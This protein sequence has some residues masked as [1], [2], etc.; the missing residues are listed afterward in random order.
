MFGF[1]RRQHGFITALLGCW[2]S[3]C[4]IS[5]PDPVVT[6]V[7]PDQ[8]WR[9]ES[10]LVQILG[11]NFMPGFSVEAGSDNADLDRDFSAWLTE[12]SG[13]FEDIPLSGVSLESYTRLQGIVPPGL[14]TGLYDLRVVGPT[15][16]AGSLAGA[17]TVSDSQADRL[18]L[19]PDTPSTTVNEPIVVETYL[20]DPNGDR[21]TQADVEVVLFLEDETGAIVTDA[22]FDLG[23]LQQPVVD[24]SGTVTGMLQPAGS[25][26]DLTVE[27]PGT[28]VL[29]IADASEDLGIDSAEVL[30]Q[31]QPGDERVLS[32]TLPTGT[33]GGFQTVVGEPFDLLLGWEDNFGNPL[34][35]PADA[36]LQSDCSGFLEQVLVN[37]PTVV[38]VVLTTACDLDRI[39]SAT[40]TGASTPFIVS[41]GPV[42]RFSVSLLPLPAVAGAD[43]QVQVVARDVFS[44]E[45]SWTG[46]LTLATSNGGLQVDD[47][48]KDQFSLGEYGCVVQPTLAGSGLTLSA[49][50]DDGTAGSSDPFSV[51]ANGVIDSLDVTGPSLWVAGQ[52]EAIQVGLV[53][54]FGNPIDGSSVSTSDLVLTDD[55]GEVD[56]FFVQVEVDGHLAYECSLYTARTSASVQ[57]DYLAGSVVGDLVGIEVINGDLDHVDLTPVWP[58][59][60]APATVTA[61]QPF[62]CLVQGFDAWDNSATTLV[63]NLLDL[64]DTSGTLL[65]TQVALGLNG[66]ALV[67]LT[68]TQAGSQ[69]VDASQL[70]VVLGSTE[71]ITVQAAATDGLRVTVLEAPWAWVGVA[72]TLRVETVDVFDNRTEWTGVATVQSLG[73]ASAAQDITVTNGVGVGPFIWDG[74]AVNEQL[75]VTASGWV[76][77]SALL[78]VV[79]DCGVTGPLAAVEFGGYPEAVGCIDPL[80][81]TASISVEFTSSTAGASAL[82]RF[83]L[84]DGSG[85]V[86]MSDFDTFNADLSG[87]GTFSMMGLV[88]DGS[89]CGAEVQAHGYAGLDD[90]QPVGPIPVVPQQSTFSTGLGT[91]AVDI[92][93][94]TDCARDVASGGQVRLWVDKGEL[95]GPVASGEGLEVTLDVNGDALFDWSA[96][97]IL[98]GGMATL[99]LWV[100]SGAAGAWV[101]VDAIGDDRRPM[102]WSQSPLGEELGLVDEVVLA[103]SEPLLPA[104]V[105]PA[106]FAIS[107]PTSVGILSAGL[108]AADQEVRLVLDTTVDGMAGAWLVTATQ[109]VRDASGNRLNGDY[110]GSASDYQG[111]FGDV[112]VPIDVVSCGEASTSRSLFRPDGD[113]GLDNEADFISIP[114][115]TASAPAWWEVSV[116][117]ETTGV[118]VQRERVTPLGSVD[119]WSWDGRDASDRVVHNGQWTI[120]VIP[121]DGVGNSGLGCSVDVTVD[122]RLGVNP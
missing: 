49:V 116:Y 109:D 55:L 31:W 21:V 10:T 96:T 106:F 4:G 13:Q 98:T 7:E 54:V 39:T 113:D 14:P 37:G 84:S 88:A 94:V 66:E 47:C 64:S 27:T 91:V 45:A 51:L 107:G 11:E 100:P 3:G 25:F 99:Q 8:G 105:A 122:N 95:V 52:P 101:S 71:A 112:S 44:N 30:L 111:T 32:I 6:R 87:E 76:G 69:V 61:G 108:E 17:Y 62:D 9:G 41:P 85:Q 79:Q 15:G 22:D 58:D 68:L 75:D 73:T 121:V 80:L 59:P 29:N 82:T 48:I 2:V 77:S 16:R 20:V 46:E 92:I 83:G 67:S 72:T 74:P 114:L 117:E 104:S 5:Q 81:G 86:W 65:P 50:G 40:D 118:L 90:G 38:P 78:D 103:F 60:A 34:S 63:D 23:G 53:D 24:A 26:I 97:P 120:D 28:Y 18:M 70:G 1:F 110:S 12:R 57:V 89:G 43:L 42:D 56:C 33:S 36:L 119:S 115:T 102:V 35:D 19:S 93:G